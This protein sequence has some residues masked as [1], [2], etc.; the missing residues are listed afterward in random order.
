MDKRITS[1]DH[2]ALYLA[3]VQDPLSDVARVAKIYKKLNSKDALSFREDFAGTFALSC[4]WVQAGDKNS[5]IAV[6][7]DQGTLD[8]GVNN[9][10][11]H[12]CESEQRRLTYF[13]Q[14]SISKT[15]PVDICA[16]FNFSYC[17]FHTRK[18]LIRYFKEVHRSLESEGLLFLD[19]FGGSDSEIP[20]V[21]ERMVDNNDQLAPFTFEFVRESFNPIDRKSHYH[22]NFKYNSGEELL[23]AFQYHFRMWTI[24]EIRDC[25]K[26][27][28][29]SESYVFWE[30]CGEDGWGNGEFFE[31]NKQENTL[32]WNAYIIGKR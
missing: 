19:I 6:E 1:K 8:Y 13:C 18:Q 22:I 7:L 17:L 20:E 21:Q 11:A 16:A 5:A 9:Y 31:T 27:A 23:K 4:C 32:N 24:T 29:F 3:S 12:L 30:D 10:Y 26:D 14:D 2:H 15:S 25:L 28:G